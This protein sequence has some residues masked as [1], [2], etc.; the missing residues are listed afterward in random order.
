M[1]FIK[2]EIKL[3]IKLA[4]TLTIVVKNIFISFTDILIGN[5]IKFANG[6]SV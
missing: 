2:K 6:V 1:R 3:A 4:K 5:S